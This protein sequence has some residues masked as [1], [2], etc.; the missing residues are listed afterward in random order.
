ME[1][2]GDYAGIFWDS[3]A[4]NDIL[5]VVAGSVFKAVL[6]ACFCGWLVQSKT[7]NTEVG[8]VLSQVTYYVLLPAY[9]FTRLSALAAVDISM[10]AIPVISLLQVAVGA[11]VGSLLGQMVEDGEWRS[12]DGWHPRAPAP[13]ATAVALAAAAA[14][15]T[16]AASDA[17]LNPPPNAAPRGTKAV[18]RAACTFGAGFALPLSILGSLELLPGKF[19]SLPTYAALSSLGWLPLFWSWGLTSL[20]YASG[21]SESGDELFKRQNTALGGGT[22]KGS[23]SGMVPRSIR[24]PLGIPK[25][26]L[27]LSIVSWF[28][29]PYHTVPDLNPPLLGALSG[30]L[31]RVFSLDAFFWRAGSEP[32]A[33][34]LW[35]SAGLG[36][37]VV[38]TLWWVAPAATVVQW[39]ILG[40]SAF[41]PGPRPPPPWADRLLG[42]PPG[43]TS[44]PRALEANDD[45]LRDDNGQA[46]QA[47]ERY[48]FPGS[49]TLGLLIPKALVGQRALV[50][51]LLARGVLLPCATLG[52]LAAATALGCLPS[53]PWASRFLLLQAAMPPTQSLVTVLLLKKANR[54]LAKELAALILRLHVLLVLPLTLWCVLFWGRL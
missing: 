1:F 5:S 22:L 25:R 46:M 17:L 34:E 2:W 54:T 36:R 43:Q 8:P 42:T 23:A 3:T 7:L 10:L 49:R 15:G 44:R 19:N 41:D 6:L 12:R 39:M 21:I 33:L 14:T 4:F 11:A 52:I 53:D 35:L 13:S 51:V 32:L 40:A 16:A 45:W 26:L 27:P 28:R 38:S 31:L 9:L 48:P 30:L 37:L 24:G 50:A 20:L 29:K 18:V 47:P